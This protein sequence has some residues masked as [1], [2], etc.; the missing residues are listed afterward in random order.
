MSYLSLMITLNSAVLLVLLVLST[1]HKLLGLEGTSFELHRRQ[2][3][4]KVLLI[5]LC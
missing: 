2:K 1:E 3:E 4:R 5:T